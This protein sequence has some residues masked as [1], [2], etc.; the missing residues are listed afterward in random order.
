MNKNIMVFVM[1]VVIFLTLL[2]APETIKVN[3]MGIV[4]HSD[5]VIVVDQLPYVTFPHDLMYVYLGKSNFNL[6]IVNLNTLYNDT[7]L[8]TL[9][10]NEYA[11]ANIT[12]SYSVMWINVSANDLYISKLNTLIPQEVNK[13][14]PHT[15][16]YLVITEKY[17]LANV[18]SHKIVIGCAY[19]ERHIGYVFQGVDDMHKPY[20]A[21]HEIGH[22]L[23]LVH[24]HDPT[25]IMYPDYVGQTHFDSYS[26]NRLKELH[27][28]NT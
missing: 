7:Y 13:I 9:L 15:D 25:D 24:T 22:L 17:A 20:V 21:M 27:G 3:D 4:I 14:H 5:N 1:S 11:R 28:T 6:T 12:F 10:S 23:G 2:I 18:G 8:E 16:L 19:V 26:L